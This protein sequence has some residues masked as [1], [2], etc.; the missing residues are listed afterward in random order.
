[1]KRTLII[2]IAALLCGCASVGNNFDSRK[3]SEVKKGETTESQLVG[4][5]GQPTQRGINSDG[6]VTM[7]WIYSEA[8]AK[9]ATFIPIVG[10][11]AG[12]TNIK[13]KI[14]N[15]YLDQLGKVSS[16]NYSGGD[17]QAGG[18]TQSEPSDST[19]QVSS[20]KSPRMK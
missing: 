16:Y 4:L 10:A 3:L 14:L 5:F 6:D 20:L 11:F 2:T 9:G 15:V 18:G 13:T 12:G 19:N 1:M 7:Q 17:T 8:T